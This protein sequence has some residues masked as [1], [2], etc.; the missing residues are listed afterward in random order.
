V[1]PAERDV[2]GQKAGKSGSS[3]VFT[4]GGQLALKVKAMRTAQ[5]ESKSREN[6]GVSTMWNVSTEHNPS[7]TRWKK[8]R[9]T[10]GL[11]W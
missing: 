10:P 8:Y 6:C 7:R 1:F 4:A 9:P 2:G 5:I 11:L 3:I